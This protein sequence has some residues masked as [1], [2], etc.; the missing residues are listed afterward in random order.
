MI[1][2]SLPLVNGVS[3]QNWSA[4]P[5][6][7]PCSV[8]KSTRDHRPIQTDE[9]RNTM[10]TLGLM[11]SDLVGPI[12]Y[13]SLNGNRYFIQMYDDAT[14]ASMVRFLNSKKE[15]GEAVKQMILAYE[16]AYSG[17]TGKLLVKRLR[18]DNGT[19][20]I[21]KDLRDWL[22]K[23]GIEH[24]LAAPYPPES[25]GKAERLNRTILD[26]ARTLLYNSKHIS[27][28]KKLWAE[29]FNTAEWIRNRLYTSANNE[30]GKTPYEI[31]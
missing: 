24:E 14:G 1:R 8:A 15:A 4:V 11:H 7:E 9:A 2:K 20:F 3:L 16:T 6:F 26:M 21:N 27:K 25:N 29:F 19:E 17:T 30:P 13:P 18:T 12:R 10:T 28:Y 22:K 31:M 23:K 5:R